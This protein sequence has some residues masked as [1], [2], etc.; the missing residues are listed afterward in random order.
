MAVK[1]N[2]I[3]GTKLKQA[4]LYTKELQGEWSIDVGAVADRIKA[5]L[6]EAE[7]S[8]RYS[9]AG[10]CIA[11]DITREKLALW[12]SG[13]YS[14]DDVDDAMPNEALAAC[15]DMALLHLQRYWEESD[16]PGTLCIKQLEA[17]GALGEGKEGSVMPPFDLGRHKKYAR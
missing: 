3:S 12:R 14:S 11:L 4:G 16:K 13:Y 8:G 7:K 10:L 9:V 15:L 5:Y 2:R 17:T 6:S 1:K